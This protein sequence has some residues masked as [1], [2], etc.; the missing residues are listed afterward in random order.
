MKKEVMK[1]FVDHKMSD[2]LN[3]TLTVLIPNV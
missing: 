1:V 2:S 3:K